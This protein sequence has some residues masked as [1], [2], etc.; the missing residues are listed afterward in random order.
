MLLDSNKAEREKS[1][2]QIGIAHGNFFVIEENQGKFLRCIK[3]LY[4]VNQL[5]ADPSRC[6]STNRQN[7]PIQQ[8]SCNL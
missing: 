6:N 2:R 3:K 5:I 7:S 8:K 1:L 4:G